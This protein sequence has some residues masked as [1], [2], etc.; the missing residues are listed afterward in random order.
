M[1][2]LALSFMVAHL[3]V[4]L[5]KTKQDP[6]PKKTGSNPKKKPGSSNPLN[7]RRRPKPF[8]ATFQ[9]RRLNI[10]IPHTVG[11]FCYMRYNN[12]SWIEML[13][14]LQ[15]FLQNYIEDVLVFVGVFRFSKHKM[16]RMHLPLIE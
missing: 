16:L 7:V 11:D 5:R 14:K 6:N 15:L 9:F 13:F 2:L 3:C 10:I 12:F 1:Q 8:E 4:R